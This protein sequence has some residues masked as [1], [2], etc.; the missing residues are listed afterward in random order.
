MQSTGTLLFRFAATSSG[1]I[2]HQRSI[3]LQD[4]NAGQGRQMGLG[5]VAVVQNAQMHGIV[6]LADRMDATTGLGN[7]TV[8]VPAGPFTTYTNDDGSYQLPNLPEGKISVAFFHTGYV[9]ATLDEVN[10]QAGQDF[11]AAD[12]LL[13]PEAMAPAPGSISGTVLFSVAP[14]DVTTTVIAAVDS[15]G[16]AFA[17][18]IKADG[19]FQILSVPAGLY[20]ISVSHTAYL[21][22]IVNH[23]LVTSGAIITVPPVVLQAGTGNTACNPGES[24]TPST[25]CRTGTIDCSTGIP[26]CKVL[27]NAPDGTM[28]GVDQVCSAGAC[29]TC[30]GG[31]MCAPAGSACHQGVFSCSTGTQVCID[32]EIN[33]VDGQSCGNGQVCN[34]GQ[35]VACGQGN[36]CTP[37]ANVCHAG[38]IDC[39]SGA[40][41]CKDTGGLAN[42]GTKCG[43]D[44][45]CSLG[46]CVLCEAGAACTPANPCHAGQLDCSSG[47]PVCQDTG[48]AMDGTVCGS[49]Q[50][51]NQGT[52]SAC[53]AGGDCAPLAN[54]CHEGIYSCSTGTQ[55]CVDKEINAADGLTCGN[56]SQVCN[57]GHCIAC[58]QGASCVPTNACHTGSID[59]STGSPVCTDLGATLSNGQS[60]G[61]DSVCNGGV[62]I[63]CKGGDVCTPITNACHQGQFACNTGIKICNDLARTSPTVPAAAWTSSA[64]PA[65]AT[66]AS[67]APP[68][69]RRARRTSATRA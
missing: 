62:C 41:I 16:Q 69:C 38:A 49:D 65:A 22:A 67:P 55:V 63:A 28:C 2:D 5:D 48:D 34:T 32:E 60:C 66:P 13:A 27:A 39:A 9:P 68:A 20:D 52:C 31:G 59:C 44:K 64:T 58:A 17:G 12:V 53:K 61:M 3:N 24:C 1:K 56:G 19:T 23:V 10:L 42:D 11:A 26:Q 46:S 18:S 15:T 14:P 7:T 47:S 40:P 4:I 50:V 43:V 51:C 33:A 21:T 45:V 57:T 36:T 25:A 29:T 30:K 37:S 54:D 8:F 35:C 6:K